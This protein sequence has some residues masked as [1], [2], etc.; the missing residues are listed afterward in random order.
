MNIRLLAATAIVAALALAGCSSSG[1]GSSPGKDAANFIA[2]LRQ[3]A[4]AASADTD[5]LLHETFAAIDADDASS[6]Y[7]IAADAKALHDHLADFRSAALGAPGSYKTDQGAFVD[8]ENELKNAAGSVLTWAGDPN[9]K[10]NAEWQSQM[11]TAVR[12]WNAAVKKLWTA[13]GVT[14]APTIATSS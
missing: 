5:A 1:G 8:A 10:T 11:V 9:P 2:P 13:A 12:D 3:D 6:L 7:T 14:P 4:V